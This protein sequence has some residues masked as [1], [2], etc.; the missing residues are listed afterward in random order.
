MS[1]ATS[2]TTIDASP[3]PR[4]SPVRRE[5]ALFAR[6]WAWLSDQPSTPDAVLRMLV[7]RA[8]RDADDTYKMAQRKEAC[9]FLMRDLIGDDA[10]F[11]D[12]SR[13]L[14]AGQLDV[15]KT[16]ATHWPPQHATRIIASASQACGAD[17]PALTNG[18][19]TSWTK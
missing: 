7:E 4:H 9:Y 3:K 2:N 5:I 11:E 12:A 8:S 17:Q 1:H 16:L 18:E 19:S 6:H 13:A 10:Y 15:I 14:F